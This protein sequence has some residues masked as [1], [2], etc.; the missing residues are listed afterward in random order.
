MVDASGAAVRA[1][2][3]TFRANPGVVVEHKTVKSD[4]FD[5]L[6][7]KL[8]F[9]GDVDFLSIDIDGADYWLLNA[10]TATRTRV[11][12]MEYNALFGPER[13]VTVPDATPAKGT[14]KGYAGASLAALEGCARRKGYRLVL[15]EDAGVN[16]F[17]VRDDLAPQVP[18]LT[19]AQ[20]WR[21]RA[22]R[23]AVDDAPIVRDVFGEIAAQGLP[24]VEV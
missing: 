16:A 22:S 21:P 2:R 13:S 1:A 15:C 24:L 6:I 7:T 8:G 10:L 4:G 14:P 9:A 17:F 18:T 23:Y 11:L 12:C 5:Q 20:A 3:E 19:A